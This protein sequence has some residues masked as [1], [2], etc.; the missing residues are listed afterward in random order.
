MRT[1]KIVRPDGKNESIVINDSD[2]ILI[3]N[4]MAVIMELSE[5]INI[6]RNVKYLMKSIIAKMIDLTDTLLVQRTRKRYE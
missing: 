1:L 4:R 5:K 6:D 3:D 2:V